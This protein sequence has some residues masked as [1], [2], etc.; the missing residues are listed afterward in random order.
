MYTEGN[1]SRMKRLMMIAALALTGCGGGDGG[2]SPSRSTRAL[3]ASLVGTWTYLYEDTQCREVYTFREN[4]RYEVIS[5]DS[6][7]SG[8]Y[9]L[10]G[11]GERKHLT[12]SLDTDNGM[13][14][15]LGFSDDETN[16]ED[17]SWVEIEESKMYLFKNS[18]G[19]DAFKTLY[20]ME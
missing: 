11:N 16:Q 19:G 15:C 3:T 2:S 9:S 20:R 12:V 13:P 14:D 18:A 5:L 17:S 4:G 8:P 1:N 6:R 10:I 7:L